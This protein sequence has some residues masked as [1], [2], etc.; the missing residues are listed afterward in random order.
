MVIRRMMNTGSLQRRNKMTK[1]EFVIMFVK[2]II[3]TIKMNR[4]L[5]QKLA[6]IDNWLQCFENCRRTGTASLD[7][8]RFSGEEIQYFLENFPINEPAMVAE[9]I[10]QLKQARAKL[11]AEGGESEEQRGQRRLAEILA[12]VASDPPDVR[13]RRLRA[14]YDIAEDAMRDHGQSYAVMAQTMA[15]GLYA[16]LGKE[17]RRSARPLCLTGEDRRAEGAKTDRL[18]AQLNAGVP[19]EELDLD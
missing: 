18:L 5:K 10:A 14:W 13:Q 4:D 6:H 15:M 11:I 12:E 9:G 2:W 19:L 7:A 16:E 1:L 17:Q 8:S 3:A